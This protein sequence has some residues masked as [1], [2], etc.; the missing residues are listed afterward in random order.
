M[1]YRS[2]IQP[3]MFFHAESGESPLGKVRAIVSDDAMRIAV[4]QDISFRNL[5]VVLPSSF[6]IGFTSTHLV[7]LSTITK[8]CV[9]FPL[10][11][12]NGPTISKHHVAKGHVI[13]IVFN[14]D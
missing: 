1:R 8:I 13:G 3:N 7:N 14:A 4:S 10:A 6:R 9:M 11:G 5:I 12:R 2:Q